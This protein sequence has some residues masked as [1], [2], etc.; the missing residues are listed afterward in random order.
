MVASNISLMSLMLAPPENLEEKLGLQL[1]LNGEFVT[2]L[3][4]EL[5]KDNT[6]LGSKKEA[7]PKEPPPRKPSFKRE[8]RD[9]PVSSLASHLDKPVRVHVAGQPVRSG[10]LS[11]VT[12]RLIAVE[13]RVEGGK[14]T[15]HVSLDD[16][17]R[18]EIEFL[19]RI[20]PPS[21]T[22]QA[23]DQQAAAGNT[24]TAAE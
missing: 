2:D 15:A 1:T 7:G 11:D 9:V 24:E 17:E 8:F 23:Q 6:L 18:V 22:E 21:T 16:A 4:I 5:G 10:I 20:D 14:F 12:G 3:G 13:Q 19:V